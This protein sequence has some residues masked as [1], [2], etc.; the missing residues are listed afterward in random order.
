MSI[1][2]RVSLRT[3]CEGLPVSGQRAGPAAPE[4]AQ[5]G[6]RPGDERH[7]RAVTPLHGDAFVVLP[8]DT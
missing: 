7:L 3:K 1:F 4:R 8:A 5:Q 6:K 2:A